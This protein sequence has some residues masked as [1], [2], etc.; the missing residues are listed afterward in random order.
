MPE[1]ILSAA[2]NLAKATL[3]G[4][5]L[6]CI[7]LPRANLAA[8]Q[9]SPNTI[10]D[11]IRHAAP[12]SAVTVPQAI[13][14]PPRKPVRA[15]NAALASAPAARPVETW[16]PQTTRAGDISRADKGRVKQAI[17]LIDKG[18]FSGAR[19]IA[20][21][22]SHP[23]ARGVVE[24]IILRQARDGIAVS[25]YAAF[26]S[27]HR[28]WPTERIQARM[29]AALIE[30][31]VPA[32]AALKVLGAFPPVSG[33]GHLALALAYQ[34]SGR[35][36]EAAAIIRT[37]WRT[38]ESFGEKGEQHAARQLGSY[39]GTADSALRMRVLL[40]D[41]RNAEGLRAASYLDAGQKKLAE[42]WVAVNKRSKNAGAALS[43]VPRSLRSDPAYQFIT[44]QWLRRTGKELDAARMLLKAPRDPK[45]LVDRDE[46]WVE[47]RLAARSALEAGEPRLAYQVAAGHAA[48]TEWLQIE[49]EF[50]AGWIALRF[51]GDANTATRHFDTAV[52]L[53]RTPISRSRAHY[54]MG[55]ALHAAGNPNATAH[56]RAAAAFPTT[57]YG[58]LAINTLG[59]SEIRIP[60][61]PPA[62]RRLAASAPMQA[63]I[64][65]HELGETEYLGT[66]FYDLRERLTDAGDIAYLAGR[67]SALD[68]TH[69][70][71]RIGKKATQDG[72]PFERH[73]FPV[74]TVPRL[75]GS[76]LPEIALIYAISRQ[77]SEFNA[78]ARSPAGARGLM[79]VMPATAKGIAKRN[80]YRYSPQK[81]ASDPSYNATFGATY[82]GERIGQFNGSYILAVASYNAGK[83]NVDKWIARFG[84]PRDPR[85]DPIDWVELI[86]F[87]ETRNYV[88]R[89]MENLQ[90]YRALLPGTPARVALARD[91]QRGATN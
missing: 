82:L 29:E 11:L 21:G 2:K 25:D 33:E 85:V 70:E 15:T 49:A 37:A 76:N 54:W 59:G 6:S 39:L 41:E 45:V 42:A 51:I 26:L 36:K 60:P 50:H 44:I 84:D 18:D 14:L 86:P 30:Q 80:G 87:T 69:L 27:A 1:M 58:Q 9:T 43:A 10:A 32:T 3:V 17:A 47:R 31:D 77:E 74:G 71:V 73:A 63:V 34:A 12:G 8:Q 61:K 24:Y 57:Y 64:L 83:G 40:Y 23:V 46:W 72:L 81:L 56:F 13:P 48:E 65:L 4:V 22:M 28:D 16:T 75:K 20:A 62:N 91:L 79:Q 38:G 78:S 88:Q 19:A 5:L 67:A 89:V 66:F 90:V 55:R 35:K 68:L 52:K 7:S 53:A